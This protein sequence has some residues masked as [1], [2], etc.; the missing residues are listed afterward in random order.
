MQINP[1]LALI[2]SILVGVG[3]QLSLKA[4]ATPDPNAKTI[5]FVHPYILVGLGSYFVASIFYIYS[6]RKL[7]LSVA[8][9]S[10]SVSYVIVSL[11][12]HLIWGEPFGLRQILALCLICSG[13]FI[14]SRGG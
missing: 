2:T 4:G 14:L 5:L 7:P 11:L 6:L 10:V 13:V 3:G 1:Y 8:F 12:A 9:P